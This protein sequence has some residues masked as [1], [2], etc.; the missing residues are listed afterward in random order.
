M[1]GVEIRVRSDSRPAQRDLARLDRSI[2]GIAK[3]AKTVERAIQAIGTAFAFA[4]ASA[5]FWVLVFC[6]CLTFF[7]GVA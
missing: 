6:F 2:R 1:S 7:L 3:S 4:F 5:D